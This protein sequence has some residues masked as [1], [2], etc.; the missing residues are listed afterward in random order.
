[1]LVLLSALQRFTCHLEHFGQRVYFSFHQGR[2]YRLGFKMESVECLHDSVAAGRV[3]IKIKNKNLK[4]KRNNR[5]LGECV[6]KSH[7]KTSF[8][9]TE[10]RVKHIS[11]FF[12]GL[13]SL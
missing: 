12:L 4:A 5:Q 9:F 11:R 6:F 2:G 3:N 8:F 7:F 10:Q 13:I 1:M